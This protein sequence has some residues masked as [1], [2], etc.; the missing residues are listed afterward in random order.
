MCVLVLFSLLCEDVAFSQLHAASVRARFLAQRELQAPKLS[1]RVPSSHMITVQWHRVW[2]R[3]ETRAVC[4]SVE[5]GRP[6]PGGGVAVA[7]DRATTIS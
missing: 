7:G 4:L 2:I 5:S 3:L 6:W 1:P